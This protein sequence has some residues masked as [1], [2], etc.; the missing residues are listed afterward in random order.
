MKN[1]RSTEKFITTEISE[2]EEIT[3]VEFGA[4]KGISFRAF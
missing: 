1:E 4:R 2:N 3:K